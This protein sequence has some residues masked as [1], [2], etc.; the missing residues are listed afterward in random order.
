IALVLGAFL[1]IFQLVQT[2]DIKIDTDLMTE[3]EQCCWDAIKLHSCT[4]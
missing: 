4:S 2:G 1:K 3:L